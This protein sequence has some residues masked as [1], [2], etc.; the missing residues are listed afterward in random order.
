[1][2]DTSFLLPLIRLVSG[3]IL[4]SIF[5]FEPNYLSC[6]VSDEQPLIVVSWM[7]F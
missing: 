3:K 5:Q 4:L 7:C 6:F 1:M 2:V